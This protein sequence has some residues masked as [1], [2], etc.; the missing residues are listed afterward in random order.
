MK[1]KRTTLALLTVLLVSLLLFTACVTN[2][3][4]FELYFRVD[5][6]V[7]STVSTTG[8][9][10]IA[11]PKDP[12]KE[13]Y[14]FNGWYWDEGIWEKPF[15]AYS[16]LDAPISSNM[17]VYAKFVKIADQPITPIEPTITTASYKVE[18]YL[19]NLSDNGYTKTDEVLLQGTISQE[20][21][22]A[23]KEYAHFTATQ[24]EVKGTVNK[25]G[26]LVLRR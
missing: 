25:D 6:Q 13:G 11:V 16:L 4:K 5:G 19:E 9:E 20:V 10:A 24:S 7:Y 12:E 2:P 1:A 22:A 8:H 21:T 15:T 18:Y 3:V 23:I 14:T 26:T 17:S